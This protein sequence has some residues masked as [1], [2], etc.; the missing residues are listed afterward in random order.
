VIIRADDLG[1]EAMAAVAGRSQA[2]ILSHPPLAPDPLSVTVPSTGLPV[3]RH[4]LGG[5]RNDSGRKN[6]AEQSRR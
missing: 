5:H 6:W 4:F 3:Q 2:E 1:R